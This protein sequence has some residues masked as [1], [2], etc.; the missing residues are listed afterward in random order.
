MPIIRPLA[1]RTFTGTTGSNNE[2]DGPLIGMHLAASFGWRCCRQTARSSTTDLP[3]LIATDDTFLA[4][5]AS[6]FIP[7]AT[8][9]RR[10]FGQFREHVTQRRTVRAGVTQLVPTCGMR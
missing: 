9:P 8:N 10:S 1:L 3:T 2:P 5:L 7:L 6:H 4:F